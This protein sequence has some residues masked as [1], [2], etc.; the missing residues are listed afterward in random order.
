MILPGRFHILFVHH[1]QSGVEACNHELA[2]RPHIP[3]P[4]FPWGVSPMRPTHAKP[5]VAALRCSSLGRMATRIKCTS[6]SCRQAWARNK[7][8]SSPASCSRPCPH[9][10]ARACYQHPQTYPQ[11]RAAG[12]PRQAFP[13]VSILHLSSLL[14]RAALY[15]SIWTSVIRSVFCQR[16][17]RYCG[18]CSLLFRFRNHL[19]SCMYALG[20]SEVTH[21]AQV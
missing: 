7:Q 11:V 9:R 5:N 17:P 3:G 2:K 8:G 16:Y 21:A 15:Y 20:R 10:T 18:T 6:Q 4:R 14:C 12:P 19:I 13:A 1:K